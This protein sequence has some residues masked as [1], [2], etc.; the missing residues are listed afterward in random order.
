MESSAV[1]SGGHPGRQSVA[2]VAA[3]PAPAVLAARVPP[4]VVAPVVVGRQQAARL[5]LPVAR[6][7][8]YAHAHGIIHRDIKPVNILMKTENHP[9]LSDFGIAKVLEDSGGGS[10]TSTGVA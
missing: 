8:E 6:A 9:M 3:V 10:L 4:I 1:E 7:M 5:L 2:V